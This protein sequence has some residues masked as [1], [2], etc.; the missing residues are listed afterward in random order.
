MLQAAQTDCPPVL[1]NVLDG[2]DTHVDRPKPGR[3]ANLPGGQAV[4][5]SDPSATPV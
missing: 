5:V 4:Q 3:L 1:V 2:Q